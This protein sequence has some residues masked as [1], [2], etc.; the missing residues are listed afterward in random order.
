MGL[1]QMAYSVPPLSER[2]QRPIDKVGHKI[3]DWRKDWPLH[4]V[5]CEIKGADPSHWFCEAEI[6]QDDLAKIR[7]RLAGGSQSRD[8]LTTIRFLREAD[9]ALASGR[10]VYY[11]ANQ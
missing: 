6:T 11:F 10:Q 3:G 7:E 9:D 5:V 8:A 2:G 4:E 1:D